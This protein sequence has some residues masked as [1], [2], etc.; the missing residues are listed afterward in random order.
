MLNKVMTA[1]LIGVDADFVMVETD[2]QMGLPAVNVVGLADTTIKEAKERIKS[3]IINSGFQFPIRRITINL[4]PANL[5]K[6]GSHFD[7]PIA[8]GILG[9][10]NSNIVSDGIGFAGE[11]S[12]DGSLKGIRGVLPLALCLR[13]EGIRKM[14]VPECNAEEAAL[15]QDMEI[16]PVKNLWECIGFLTGKLKIRR[17]IIAEN[18][19]DKDHDIPDF[20]DVIG[21]ESA[22]RALVI[23][24]AGNHGILM[25]G[26]PGSGKTMMAR[27]LPYIMPDMTY[28]EML[29]VAK[30][31]SS[32]GALDRPGPGQPYTAR[33]QAGGRP[34][35]PVSRFERPFRAPHHSITK[36]ALIGGGRV[37]RPGELSMAHNG[38]LFLD[39]F[40]EFDPKIIELLR[41]PLEEG[42]IRIDRARASVRLP[43]NIMLVAAA[44]PCRCGYLGDDKHICTC[45]DAQLRQY[46]SKFSGP[47]LD[48]IDMH[49]Q[50]ASVMQ[51]D[52]GISFQSSDVSGPS[53]TEVHQQTLEHS[54]YNS[55]PVSTETMR[56]E[57]ERAV[58]IQKMRYAGT[59]IKA[60]GNLTEKAIKKYC[61]MTPDAE[62]FIKDA[63]NKLGF[64]MRTYY[65]MLK[66]ARTIADLDQENNIELDGQESVSHTMTEN[67][68]Q[69]KH[70]AEAIQYRTLDRFY[71][72]DSDGQQK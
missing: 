17:Y 40:G 59:S 31:H 14:V 26:S 51:I 57:V 48:R 21:Q 63:F 32:A 54:Q 37:P 61:I 72:R 62:V 58:G 65:K 38:I 10:E 41:Q 64:S 28:D 45:T 42:Y 19:Y 44:N 43:G 33:Q 70:I 15:I 13:E 68:I 55:S 22:K 50:V 1:S 2:L 35:P 67:P 12:L 9:L 29:E 47:M 39:E 7:L 71:R 66:V 20:A 69:L 5:P 18:R 53:H 16:Y 24:A 4:S 3:A 6:E 23:A 36:A 46:F 27:R 60:N 52:D 25:M 11:L 56:K 30:I 8:V 49:I 34:L